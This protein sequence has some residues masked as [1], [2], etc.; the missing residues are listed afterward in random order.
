MKRL[1]ILVSTIC[2][3]ILASSVL[4]ESSDLDIREKIL[5]NFQDAPKKEMFKVYHFLYKKEY[6]LNSEEGVRRYRIFKNTLKFIEETNSKNL[7]YKLGVNKF[8]DLSDEEFRDQF[9]GFKNGFNLQGEGMTREKAQEYESI[10]AAQT[11][12]GQSARFNWNAHFGPAKDQGSCGSCWAFAAV[13]AIEGNYSKNF[14]QKLVFA[15]QQLVDCSS[16]TNGCRGS[17]PRNAMRYIQESGIAYQNAY[18]YISGITT[19]PGACRYTQIKPNYVLSNTEFCHSA[20]CTRAVIQG[21]LSKGPLV[22]LIDGEGNGIFK[23]YKTGI[24]DMPC[25]NANHAIIMTG[26]DFD[27]SRNFYLGRNSWGE[28]WGEKGN[29]K[30]YV[31]DSDRTCFMESYGLL[32]LVKQTPV[33]V[34]PAPAPECLKLYS[35]CNLKGTVTETCTSQ[36]DISVAPLGFTIGKFKQVLFFTGPKCTNSW[37]TLNKSIGCMSSVGINVVLK[38]LLIVEEQLPPTG[39]VWIY[40]NYCLAGERKEI[41]TDVDDLARHSFA[42]K[43]SSIKFGPGV[44]SVTVY[45]DKVF[46]GTFSTYSGDRFSL[47]NSVLDNNIESIK[48]TK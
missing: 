18:S 12:Y 8:S 24:I 1:L 32:P 30:I 21:M 25:A 45:T 16:Y 48:I 27:G 44:K 5:S 23:S 40:D 47:F 36:P 11:S 46:R 10:H 22:A 14:G 35:Q 31:R 42:N 6:E 39:C 34:P 38:S 29:F 43:T 15:E 20:T 26:L 2:L 33:P 28:D 9:L 41:C 3:L 13:G 19:A 17:D 4:I 7:S 37:Y